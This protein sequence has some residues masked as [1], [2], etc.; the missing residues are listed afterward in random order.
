M[1]RQTLKLTLD[2]RTWLEQFI[3]R[4]SVNHQAFKREQILLA[5]AELEQI[6]A[7]ELA[8][9]IGMSEATIYN[10]RRRY[11]TVGVEATVKRKARK[12]RKSMVVSRLVSSR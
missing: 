5:A 9:V 4:G 12:D 7:A 11:L 3:G 6:T 10:T 8:K 1:K 2:E